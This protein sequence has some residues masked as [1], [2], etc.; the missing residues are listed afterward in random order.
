[1]SVLPDLNYMYFYY[2]I[3]TIKILLIECLIN[4]ISDDNTAFL[5]ST[6]LL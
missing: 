6:T 5:S 2:T 4:V 3:K 1:M